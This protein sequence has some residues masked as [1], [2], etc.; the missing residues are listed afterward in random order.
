[1]EDADA[2]LEREISETQEELCRTT[3]R[4]EQQAAWS[5]LR[6]LVLTRSPRQVAAMEMKSGL[7]AGEASEIQ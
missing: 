1:M 6:A 3:A 5:R 7:L 2:I 4:E